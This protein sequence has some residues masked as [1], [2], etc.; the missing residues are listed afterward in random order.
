MEYIHRFASPLGEIV[1][2]A[3]GDALTGLYFQGQ[4][5]MPIT[6]PEEAAKKDLPVF[7][8]AD[9]WLEL[10][11]GGRIPDFTPPLAP[12]GTPFRQAVWE[13]LLTIPYGETMTYGPI[14]GILSQRPGA[15]RTSARAVG[16][17]TGHN[18]VALIIPCHRVVGAGGAL[19]GYAGGTERKA[20]LLAL[21]KN[22][23]LI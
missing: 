14:A 5:H 9:R 4:K 3:D 13:V 7:D 21:E 11:F 2:T 16:G 12:A 23:I 17:A 18:P 8:Q 15:A 10:Y 20:R 22:G 1:M 19:T 6:K